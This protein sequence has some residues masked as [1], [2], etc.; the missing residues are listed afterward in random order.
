MDEKIRQAA[1]EYIN[2]RDRTSHPDGHTDR[3]GRWYPSDSECC[4]CCANV[5]T[6]SRSWPWS[7]MTHCRTIG[8]VANLYGVPVADVRRA[9]REIEP[10]KREGG[11]NYYKAVAVTPDGRLVSIFD[12]ETEYRIGAELHESAHRGHTGGYYVYTTLDLA[13]NATVPDKSVAKDLPRAFLRCAASGQYCRYDG[14]KLA[15]SRI[16][17]LEVVA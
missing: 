11:E 10:P 4:H 12:G 15:F 6:P 1:E 16:T 2:R 14:S 17:P 13:R 3:G 8:H 5:R 9:V 7:Y